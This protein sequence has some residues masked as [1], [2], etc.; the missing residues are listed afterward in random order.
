MRNIKSKTL[1]SLVTCCSLSLF[2]SETSGS[3]SSF[4]SSPLSDENRIRMEQILNQKQQRA[5]EALVDMS[6]PIRHL[7]FSSTTALEEDSSLADHELIQFIQEN[8]VEI[9]DG[10]EWTVVSEDLFKTR[11]WKAGDPLLLFPT[12]NREKPFVL[13]NQISD[14]RVHVTPFRG[15]EDG[16]AN[17][18]TIVGVDHVLGHAYLMKGDGMRMTWVI[19]K[20]YLPIFQEWTVN[21]KII[22]AN[23]DKC[24]Y[25]KY[26]PWF[27]NSHDYILVNVAKFN[28]I[29]AKPL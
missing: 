12:I 14:S 27:F 29:P 28:N 1:V 19:D 10:S 4:N 23:Y 21:H 8:V 20:E 18:Y 9:E 13:Y 6:I 2:A 3:K 22:L 26:L 15:P 24:W 17:A 5:E 7:Q 25:E 16:G 11:T